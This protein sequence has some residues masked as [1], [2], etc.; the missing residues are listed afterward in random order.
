MPSVKIADP[1]GLRAPECR[2]LSRER[3]LALLPRL[4]EHRVGLVIAPAGSGKTTLLA[5]LSAAATGPAAHLMAEPH[6]S[7]E[8]ALVSALERSLAAVVPGLTRGWREVHDALDALAGAITQPTLL[9]VDDFHTLS[10][11]PAEAAFECFLARPPPGSQ[12][13]SPAARDPP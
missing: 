4:W 10:G 13:S 1:P 6:H 5:Q 8:T 12:S 2:S 3:L 11:A 9:V 7:E